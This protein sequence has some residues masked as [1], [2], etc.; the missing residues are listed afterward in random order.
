MGPYGEEGV[1][2]LDALGLEGGQRQG[3]VGGAGEVV[4]GQ[5]RAMDV[6]VDA[7]DSRKVSTPAV[8]SVE[9]RGCPGGRRE[10]LRPP[11]R[12]SAAMGARRLAGLG[13]GPARVR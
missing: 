8:T 10:G 7:R 9:R 6:A 1:L 13:G 3:A 2:Q 5:R 4:A 11:G 12:A